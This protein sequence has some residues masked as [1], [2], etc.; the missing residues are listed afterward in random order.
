VTIYEGG[1]QSAV[2]VARNGNVI[3]PGHEVTD[4]FVTIPVTLD[5]MSVFVE[6][7][8]SVTVGQDIGVV[9]L[10]RWLRHEVILVSK[11]A[12]E[13]ETAAEDGGLS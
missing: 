11:Y 2:D 9:I 5:L 7:A 6:F 13:G 8:A 10:E 3:W 12:L 1:E 4:R